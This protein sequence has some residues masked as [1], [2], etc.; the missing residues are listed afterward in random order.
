MSLLNN[1]GLLDKVRFNP[2]SLGWLVYVDSQNVN[3]SGSNITQFNDLSGNSNNF[4]QATSGNQAI[5]HSGVSW[6]DGT[7]DFYE[8]AHNVAF[9]PSGDC[10][11]IITGQLFE[12]S[13]QNSTIISKGTINTGWMFEYVQ[14]RLQVYRNNVAT[15]T[16]TSQP[17]PTNYDKTQ[18][19]CYAI[20]VSGSNIIFYYDGFIA[21]NT[22]AGTWPGTNTSN[23][24]I[25]A[26]NSGTLWP[27]TAKMRNILF[28]NSATSK[29]DVQKIFNYFWA[30]SSNSDFTAR[31]TVCC[32]GNS[33]TAGLKS[34]GGNTYPAQMQTLLGT[35]YYVQNFGVTGQTITDML[36]DV[37]AQID[38]THYN[39]IEKPCISICWEI[40]NAVQTADTASDIYTK[41]TTYCLGR[42][43][44]G[45]KTIIG[46]CIGS[47]NFSSGNRA[48]AIAV[49]NLIRSGWTSIAD[50]LVDCGADS[51]FDEAATSV[52]M[53]YYDVDGTH[54]NN[55][56]YGAIA[57]LFETAVLTL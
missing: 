45:F 24:R 15:D 57:A 17:W 19:G 29:T 52:N 12:P 38:D 44:V 56:G 2:A 35:N 53:T 31:R 46:T 1:F 40:T 23:L 50:A 27:S 3:K 36:S 8:V 39:V 22:F 34:T 7:D 51:R 18:I 26:T 42:R 5:D 41:L 14:S 21:V 4:A 16:G 55:T 9:N 11:V 20:V 13:D 25:G 6:F 10:T 54:L 49:N 33:L 37:V 48:K 47:A 43:A 30:Q 32:D 28:K